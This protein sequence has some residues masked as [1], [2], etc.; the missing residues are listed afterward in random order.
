MS[1]EV[2]AG[3]DT[4]RAP[5]SQKIQQVHVGGDVMQLI[6]GQITVTI[7]GTGVKVP[8]GTTVLEAAKRVGVRIPTLCHHP[9]LCVAGVCRVCVVE[10]EGQRALQAAC[11]YPVTGSLKVRTHTRKVPTDSSREIFHEARALFQ[12][13]HLDRARIRLV[14]VRVEGIL[15]SEEVESQLVLGA[16]D[17]GWREAEEA[18]DRLSARFGSGSVRPARLLPE[19]GA[20]DSRPVPGERHEVDAMGAPSTPEP[21]GRE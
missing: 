10:V 21:T 6:G 12:A 7:D 3:A 17:R 18:V 13:L 15:D 20:Q 19:H 14:G 11:A 8:M 16:P 5:S 1:G 9:D 4:S 2:K